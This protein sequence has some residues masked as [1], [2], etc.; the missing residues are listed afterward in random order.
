MNKKVTNIKQYIPSTKINYDLIRSPD[1]IPRININSI[2]D[3]FHLSGVSAKNF[4]SH[5]FRY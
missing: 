2:R 1:L 3:N 5:L 4:K